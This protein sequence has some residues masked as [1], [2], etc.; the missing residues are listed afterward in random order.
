MPRE[1]LAVHRPRQEW[2]TGQCLLTRKT[3]AE[4]IIE[5]ILLRP[6]F[7]LFF[8]VISAIENELACIRLHAGR[9]E[10]VLQR[11]SSPFAVRR[12]TLQR[13]PIT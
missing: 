8:S 11:N 4:L 2:I 13:T 9:I 7:D 12:K 5:V 3:A 10:D 1:R 6:E